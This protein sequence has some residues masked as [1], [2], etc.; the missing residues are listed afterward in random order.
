M[1]KITILGSTGSIGESTLDVVR[2]AGGQIQVLGLSAYQNQQR[3]ETQAAEFN[4]SKIVLS[5]KTDGES[6]LVAL[7]TDPQ[8]EI[9]VVA[10]VGFAALKPTLAA[11]RAG[12]TVALANKEALVTC[13]ELLTNEAKKSGALIIPVDSEHNAL[14]QALQ[15]HSIK[16]VEKLWITGS[17]G[18]FRGK[19]RS[20][21]EK[22]DVKSA[23]NHPKWK[24]GPKITIDSASLM[25]KGLEFIEARWV[26]DLPSHQ[27]DV[28]IHPQ[29][30]VHGMVEFID[31]TMLAHLAVPDMKAAI[32]YALYYP[33]RQ[34]K[35]VERLQMAQLAHLDFEPIDGDTFPC[36]NLAKEALKIGGVAPT[37]LNAANEVAVNAFLGEKISFLKIPDLIAETLDAAPR[38][39][40]E[41]EA[42]FEMDR[43]AR[44]KAHE[45]ISSL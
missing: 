33:E 22:V 20:D 2:R 15:G 38:Q 1:K 18:P 44:Q 23:L 12:K 35:A 30:I 19:K 32:S 5:S 13:G 24:M 21:L 43:W 6:Q 39:T 26:F 9:V 8:C 41:L 11:I 14:F 36:Y 3:L 37:V 7:A 25:N 28:L 34:P 45:K 29:S 4:V 31:G 17:G 16:N 42:V 40:M 27:I 10:I